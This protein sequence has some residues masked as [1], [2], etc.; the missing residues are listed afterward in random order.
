LLHDADVRR[1]SFNA[2][3]LL[4]LGEL[5]ALLQRSTLIL[6]NDSGPMHI[7]AAL[8]RPVVALFGP[9][10]PALY[11]PP[12]GATRTIY[13]AVSCSPCLNVYN[14]KLFVCP[15]HARCMKEISTTDVLDAIR[16]LRP[17]LTT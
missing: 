16:S 8:G 14:A 12:A 13:K 15:Y 4:S 5:I 3:G 7:A 11:G 1:N 9:E 6:T 10:S 2:A 17:V